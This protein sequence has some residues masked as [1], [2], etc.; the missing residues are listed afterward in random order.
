MRSNPSTHSEDID[1]SSLWSVLKRAGLKI[2]AASLLVGAATF[3]VLSLLPQR[4]SSEAQLLVGGQGVNDPFRDPKVGGTATP[5][6]VT[7]KVDREAVASQVI[8]LRSRDLGVKLAKELDLRSKPEFNAA[9]PPS[10]LPGRLLRM[11]GVGAPR[12]GETEE[13]RVL[14]AYYR[15][16]QVYQGKDTRVITIEFT[17]QSPTLS[18]QA[19]NR[20]SEL[21]QDWLRSQG[22]SNTAGASEWL[23]PQ[24]EKLAKEVADADAEV[25]RF[26]SD[27]NLFRGGSQNTG[28]NE[29]QLSE[30]TAEL[31]R[32]SATRSEMEARAKSARELLRKGSVEAI[33]DVQRS[34]VIQGLVAQRVRA[35]REKA[36]AETSLLS[37]HPRMKQLNANVT[38]LRRQVNREAASIVEGLEKEARV[39]ALRE[40]S[41]RGSIDELKQRVG[42]T[43]GDVARLAALE[44]TAKAKRRE[45]ET[46]Q[47]SF[48]A[49]RTRGDARAVPLEAQ[50]ISKARASSVPVFPKKGPLS[51]LAAS[52]AFI[53]GLV[54][55]ITRELLAGSRR[56]A[57]V[58]RRRH[59]DIATDAA[60]Q[61]ES[62]PV[63]RV[64]RA[65]PAVIDGDA[66]RFVKLT[67]ASEVARRIASGARGASGHR[68]LLVAEQAGG[69]SW[70]TATAI[71]S[72]LSAS[73]RQVVVI[74]W[75]RDGAGIAGQD[76]IAP[77]PGM[78]D[79]LEG[80]ASFEDVIVP[81]SSSPA[82]VIACG[83]RPDSSELDAERINLVLD[84]LDEA[85]DHVVVVARLEPARDLFQSILGRFD[86]GIL[87]T[88]GRRRSVLSTVAAG[89]F[90]GFEVAD[91]DIIQLEQ[92]AAAAPV[93][94]MQLARGAAA[95]QP[96]RV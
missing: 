37:G 4:Y 9:L 2:L 7:V 22:V 93:R 68:S 48:E 89:T 50:V 54:L 90:L 39:L 52:A 84:A 92:A 80:R 79:L 67:S 53:L 11:V 86:A 95:S 64:Q 51:L 57:H 32:V 27:A 30:L 85:Y 72:A 18:A 29:Q 19:A 94:K 83:T 25:E 24:I 1:V 21:Y 35:E 58:P 56:G 43:A 14:S 13:D 38:D 23:R 20:L 77:T 82:H 62:E 26:R 36:E 75:S 87:C 42:A 31:S 44:S 5:E 66:D 41:V 73:G 81:L 55:V 88:D 76:G 17:S 91:I 12:A 47:A 78:S 6:S 70:S 3:G 45:L 34:P 60:W 15:A 96:L 71:A 69:D 61:T 40:D 49:T 46:L 33:P 74:D 8:A 63:A 59:D 10:D 65:K 16:L 28:L